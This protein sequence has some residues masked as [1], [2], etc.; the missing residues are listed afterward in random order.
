MSNFVFQSSHSS[1]TVLPLGKP[2]KNIFFKSL[3]PAHQE[4]A[5]G[6]MSRN[7]RALFFSYTHF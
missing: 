7:Q 2:T 4:K 6:L 1:L 3:R 5:L